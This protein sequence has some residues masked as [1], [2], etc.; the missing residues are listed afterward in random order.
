MKKFLGLVIFSFI[1]LLLSSQVFVGKS[2]ME[3]MFSAPVEQPGSVQDNDYIIWGYCIDN[4][5]YSIGVGEETTMSAAII[6]DREDLKAYKDADIVGIRIGLAAQSKNVSVFMKFAQEDNVSFDLPDVVKKNVG[7]KGIGFHEVMLDSP[8]KMD[9]RYIIA[10]YTATGTNNIGFDGGSCHADAC[11]I[12]LGNEWGSIYSQAVDE[13]WGSL[14]IQLMLSGDALPEREM[15]MENIL[16][17][18]VEQNKPYILRGVVSNQ[19]TTPVTEYELSYS[20]NNGDM[21][22]VKVQTMINAMET[23]TFSISIDEPMTRVGSN[24]IMVKIDKVNG[25]VDSDISNNAIV[26]P[27]TCIEEGCFFERVMVMEESTSVNCGYCPRGIVVM[28]SLKERYP[29]RY[30]G[31]AIHSTSMGSDP[32]SDYD[33]DEN[34]SKLYQNE[35]LPNSILNRKYEYEG[36]P[37]MMDKYIMQEFGANNIADAGIWIE[38]VSDIIDN[39]ITVKVSTK[40]ARDYT[41]ANYRISFVLVENDVESTVPQLNYFTGGDGMGGFE[42][43][44]QYVDMTFDDVARGIWDFSG[45]G[46][47]IP[48]EITKKQVYEYEYVIDLDEKKTL[49]QNAENVELVAMII[50]FSTAEIVN[51]T[52]SELGKTS[53]VRTVDNSGIKVFSDNGQIYVEGEYVGF[54][55]Y[56][57]NGIML[58]NHALDSNVY[59]VRIITK[60]NV[61]VRKVYVK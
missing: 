4:V 29:D 51:A 61:V 13:G 32:M 52:K 10:G 7:S 36:D 9:G 28:R 5:Q 8:K 6:I 47:S 17:N 20:V 26:K 48:A 46:G 11:Y 35:G 55:V 18:E 14:C 54:D 24:A 41:G 58:P 1:P 40:F 27:V 44:P 43:L 37:L 45:I 2:Y 50:D 21:Q 23:D 57:I 16:T 15:R 19:T 39:K 33:Y 49:I 38:S 42:N 56:D 25:D 12:N 22:S 3:R 30:I 31:I 34:I 59:L 53:G 60:D